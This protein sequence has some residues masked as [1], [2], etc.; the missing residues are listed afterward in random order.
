MNSSFFLIQYTLD[1]SLYTSRDVRLQ[2]C[3]LLSED[4]LYLYNSVVSDEMQQ[5]AAFHL[6]K[7]SF[8]G[9]FPNTKG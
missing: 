8:V 4:L 2:Y 6:V 3:I 9:Y 7:Y 5:Y 1:S